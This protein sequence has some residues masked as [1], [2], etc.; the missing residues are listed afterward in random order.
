[1][2]QTTLGHRAR[3]PRRR[4]RPGLPPPRERDRPVRGRPRRA[5]GLDLDAQRDARAR[6]RQDEQEHRQHRDALGRDGRM[7]GR[8]GAHLLPH[9]PL[10]VAAAVLAGAD[11][12]RRGGRR[13][14]HQ[15][16]AH[17]GPGDPAAP[18]R[19]ATTRT[20]RARWWRAAPAFSA[21]LDDDFNTPEAFAALFELVRG[22]NGAA[23]G[24]PRRR[25]AASRGPG[26]ADGR[27]WTSSAW[28]GSTR[29]RAPR[30]PRRSA[31]C[32]TSGPRPVRPATSPGRRAA[33]SHPG[34]RL[35]AGG[36]AG[37][38]AGLPGMSRESR[39]VVYGRNPV[40]ELLRAGRRPAHRV[41][42]A[43]AA[44]R[45]ALAG[46][47]A[48]GA[49]SAGRARPPGRHGRPPG[50]CRADRSVPLRGGVRP[51]G[52]ARAAGRAS[53]APRTRATSGRSRGW[54]R[55]PARPGWSIA[56]R[57]HAGGDG[58]RCARRR[59]APWSTCPWRGCRAS[60]PSC[61][62]RRRGAPGRRGGRRSAARTTRRIAWPP[63]ALLVLG[64]EGEGLRPR[65]REAC[66]G[67][68]ADPHG[69]QGGLPE[70]LG[71]RRSAPL[72]HERGLAGTVI[73]QFA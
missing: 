27:C 4:H 47:R 45:R 59:P 52:R 22:L 57:G 2:A 35:G 1:M 72:P 43:A 23:D 40:R 32:S 12:G 63:D 61:T 13:A 19:R 41:L 33:R 54:P 17:G 60:P 56:E 50:R 73:T 42:I 14:P 10:P 67:A 69:G 9:Q 24:A 7:A 29:G 30:R 15:R 25:R 46:G 64:S 66:V 51:V 53:T 68:G 65:V 49:R 34:P 26:P 28:P 70:P 38:H 48:G 37:G 20:W 5:H 6:R 36:H 31:R 62:T 18:A 3:R 8:G 16:A 21:A 58:R 71:G 11:G 55:P 44:R 39:E